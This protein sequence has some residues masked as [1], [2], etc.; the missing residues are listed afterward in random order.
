[1]SVFQ[2]RCLVAIH[3]EGTPGVAIDPEKLWELIETWDAEP[4]KPVFVMVPR[5]GRIES[6]AAMG[7]TRPLHLIAPREGWKGASGGVV[8]P[9][10]TDCPPIL[11]VNVQPGRGTTELDWDD[12]EVWLDSVVDRELI[13]N[14]E[15]KSSDDVVIHPT[16]FVS[17]D[18]Q[19]IATHYPR[20]G[21]EKETDVYEE[22]IRDVFGNDEV[23]EDLASLKIR[24]GEVASR[25]APWFR[26]LETGS[27]FLNLSPSFIF[28]IAAA[29]ALGMRFME[30]SQFIAAL[31]AT[32]VALGLN[33]HRSR[34]CWLSAR[35][36]A[37]ICRSLQNSGAVLDPLFPPA[38]THLPSH[39]R[40][41][42]SLAIHQAENP[43]E[44]DRSM[45]E[46]RDD[47]IENRLNAKEG[48]QIDYF[49]RQSKKAYRRQRI[50][51]IVFLVATILAL[52][53]TILDLVLLI[54][55]YPEWK[56]INARFI[57]GF[58]AYTF[59][60]IAAAAIGYLGLSETTRRADYYSEMVRRLKQ[61][62]ATMGRLGSESSITE[63]VR[64]TESVLLE[65][66]AEWLRRRVY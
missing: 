58:S 20:D 61:Q 39:A 65:E 55:D 10:E 6:L 3:W 48:G 9:E 35:S 14:G 64:E 25:H 45:T 15:A 27:L 63:A 21:E 16:W 34:R 30:I 11:S 49:S 17:E 29:L 7:W 44:D 66:F 59:P 54:G 46:F 5:P 1:M 23:P 38:A 32:L 13:F 40:L 18:G 47:Y 60:A 12:C 8:T 37:E 31:L 19:V 33:R 53:A 2:K 22:V 4:A 24:A 52:V 51:K 57:A 26:F 36:L 43:E 50:A 41:A 62:R 42:R 56:E 28:A